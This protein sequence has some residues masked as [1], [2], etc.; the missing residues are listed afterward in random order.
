[1]S[2]TQQRDY[3]DILGVARSASADEIKKAFRKKA[4]E[5]HPDVNPSADAEDMFKQLGEAADV[6]SDPQKRQVYD[7]YGHDGLKSGG[8]QTNWDFMQGFPDLNDLFS[9]FFGGDFGYGAPRRRNPNQGEH[10]RMELVVSFEEAAFGIKRDVTVP[11]LGPC[12][13]CSGSGSADNAGPSVCTTCGGQGQVRHTTQ[14]L[15][16]HFTQVGAC[17]NCNGSGRMITNPCKSCRGEGRSQT[18]HTFTVT[19]PAGVDSG[20]Q[21]RVAGEGNSGPNGGPSGDLF[22]V[23]TIQEHP[24]LQRDGYNVVSVQPVSYALLALGGSISVPVLAQSGSG[25]ESIT[26][27][28]GTAN[29]HVFTLRDFGVPVLNQPGRRGDHFVQVQIEV[30]TKLGHEERHLL[31]A[32]RELE[33]GKTTPSGKKNG[34]APHT[35]HGGEHESVLD[36]FKKVLGGHA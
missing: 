13:P 36:K 21:L 25:S 2:S 29:G 23:M 35:D 22:L 4:K 28:A 14:T 7:T 1:M 31:E 30:P 24:V 19:V 5:Y 17:P 18:K 6:L 9:T 10:I 16:G 8:Y 11:R 15:L 27:P 33:T 34:K 12:E 32:L 20:T 3:Y 26:I